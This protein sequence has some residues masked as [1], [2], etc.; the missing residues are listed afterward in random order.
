MK[1]PAVVL[2][3][4]V[5]S[6]PSPAET[7]TLTLRQALD[8][9]LQQNPD[10]VISR[11][12]QMK[13]HDQESINKGPFSPSV[14]AGSGLAYTYGFPTSIDGN[15]P[16]IVQVKTQMALYDKPQRYLVAQAAELARGAGF[17]VDQRQAEV[18]FRVASA[19]IDASNTARNLDAANQEEESLARADQLMQT[20]V[21]EGQELPLNGKKS[22]LAVAQANN[23]IE[24]LNRDAAK[25]ERGLAEIL[26]LAPGDR[27]H[28]AEGP[29]PTFESAVSEQD[30]IAAALSTSPEIKHLESDL[31]AKTL[32]IKSFKAYRQPKVDLV[33]QYSLFAQFNHFAQYF[34]HYQANNAEV[35]ASFSIPLLASSASK[36]YISNSE[37][38]AAK[39]R[40]QLTQTRSRIQRD[41]EDSYGDL[42][43]A[44]SGRALALEDLNVTR[45][46]T[47]ADL[48][49]LSE[50]LVLPGQIEQDRAEEQ[51]KWR[52]YYDAE[53]AA[54]HARLNVLRVTGRLEQA[55][56]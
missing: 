27:V 38:D 47:T 16:S 2:L 25:S 12:D 17:V 26:G 46:S 13:A 18:V 49:R 8:L 10:L 9:A 1:I 41:I 33:A 43:V 22:S 28:P 4:L 35:G 40:A 52:A 44:E 36:A 3:S 37:A 20:R 53:S 45:E 55:L 15:A 54:Q 48:A 29:L 50:G 14:Y 11:L 6:I 5:C 39:I 23:H 51:E 19:F 42:R 56:K 24:T 21:R 31:Q 32:E 30:A 7:R 34:Q